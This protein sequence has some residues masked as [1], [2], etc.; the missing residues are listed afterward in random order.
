MAPSEATGAELDRPGEERRDR[1]FQGKSFWLS[2]KVPQK[3]RF[4]DLILVCHQ[5]SGP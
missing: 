5:H 3:H 2:E 4:R 1:L